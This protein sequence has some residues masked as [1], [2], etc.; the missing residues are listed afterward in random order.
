MNEPSL[1]IVAEFYAK[2]GSEEKLAG[3]LKGLVEPSRKEAGCVQYDLHVDNAKAGHFLF[4]EIWAS[5]AH[6]DEHVRS[7]HFTAFQASVGDLVV[8]PPRAVFATRIA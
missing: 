6:V 8:E 2:A 3:L 4:F 1:T 5:Q 7:P